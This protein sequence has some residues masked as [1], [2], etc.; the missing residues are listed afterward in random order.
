[1]NL[2][3]NPGFQSTISLASKGVINEKAYIPFEHRKVPHPNSSIGSLVHLLKSSLGSGILA[4]PAAF[5]NAGL[6]FGTLGTIIVGFIC[7]HCVYVL[8]WIE[9]GFEEYREQG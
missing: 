9:K 7:T 2:A 8:N 4:M 5:K 1:A 6:A 3:T